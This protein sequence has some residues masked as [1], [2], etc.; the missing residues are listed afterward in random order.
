M[1]GE[2]PKGYEG[3]VLRLKQRLEARYLLLRGS[4]GLEGATVLVR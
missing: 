2:H 3:R 1:D 4:H